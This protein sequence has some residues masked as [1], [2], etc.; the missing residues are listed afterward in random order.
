MN[1]EIFDRALDGGTILS[2]DAQNSII[3]DGLIL[4][5]EGRIAYV[6]SKKMAPAYQ[7]TQTIDT[8][9]KLI[10]PGWINTHSHAP[11]TLFRG[12]ADDLPLQQWLEEHIWPAEKAYINPENVKIGA[13]LAILEMIAGGTTTFNDMYFFEDQVAQAAAE[14][15]MRAVIGEGILMFPTPSAQTPT[16][17]MILTKHLAETWRGHALVRISV[18]PHSPYT[19][20]SA[21]LKA[22]DSLARELGLL[23][24]IHVSETRQ[25]VAQSV[26]QYGQTPVERLLSLGVLGPHVLA[27]HC[28]HLSENDMRIMANQGSA[29]AHCPESNLKLGSG[30]AAIPAMIAAGITVAA[31]T[32]GAASN[33]DLDLLEELHTGSKIQKGLHED[34]AILSAQD[35]FRIGTIEGAKALGIEKETGSIEIGKLADLQIY[36]LHAP[37]ATPMFSP[38]SHLLY[39]LQATDLE[40]VIIHG[41]P[42]WKQGKLLTGNQEEIIEEA[43]QIGKQIQSERFVP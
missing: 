24:H 18:A 17:A 13:R 21:Q 43:R 8:H 20:S 39:S 2:A 36:D 31:G 4:I 6:G 37:H 23:L 12:L 5:R 42:V 7:A 15:G 9:G 38:M 34:P 22:C 32:D 30:I 16:E 25:E 19:L 11:M 3:E 33:N 41:K 35:W 27:A 40:W 28:V 14:L 10:C 29:V 26:A 1:T